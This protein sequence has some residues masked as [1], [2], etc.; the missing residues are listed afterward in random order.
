MKEAFPTFTS[1]RMKEAFP[2]FSFPRMKE[3]FPTF[4]S[5]RHG[6][7]NKPGQWDVSNHAVCSF[8]VSPLGGRGTHPLLLLS[9]K[10]E[11]DQWWCAILDN[12]MHTS[13]MRG[14]IYKEVSARCHSATMS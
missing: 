6:L 2:T 3:A 12:E 9:H 5:P 10:W 1:P 4:S 14:S 8:Q 7:V 13:A 11:R